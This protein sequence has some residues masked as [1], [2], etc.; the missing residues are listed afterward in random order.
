MSYK[1]YDII[2]FDNDSFV[3][4]AFNKY[5]GKNYIYLIEIDKE[6]NL[7]ENFEVLEIDN[8]KLFKIKDDVL[9]SKLVDIFTESIIQE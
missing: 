2:E 1:L 7:Q 9:F 6:E 5:N 8:G 4:S 3:V